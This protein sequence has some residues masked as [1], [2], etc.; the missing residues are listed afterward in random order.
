M[1]LNDSNSG[2]KSR[3]ADVNDMGKTRDHQNVDYLQ[4]QRCDR[5]RGGR[6]VAFLKAWF[7]PKPQIKEMCQVSFWKNMVIEAMALG[8]ILVA[9]ILLLNTCDAVRETI[10]SLNQ[11]VVK[12]CRI[13]CKID[14]TLHLNIFM[15]FVSS[16]NMHVS[17]R[18]QSTPE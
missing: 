10:L 11:F 16:R 13:R 17:K 4:P 14:R 6:I 12:C 7:D 18:F 1:T 5:S 8:H 3:R 15:I 2:S 9:V